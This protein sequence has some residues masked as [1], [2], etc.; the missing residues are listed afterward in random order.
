M[1]LVRLA[2]AA[3][4][5][6]C[7]AVGCASSRAAP[8][9]TSVQT[10]TVRRALAEDTDAARI[11]DHQSDVVPPSEAVAN[12][13]A[14]LDAI[15]LTHATPDFASAM[16]AHRDAWEALIAPLSR[17]PDERAEMHDLFGRLK[18]MPAPTGPEFQRLVQNVIATWSPVMDAAARAGVQP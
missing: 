14:A 13:V 10:S 15:D 7:I 3:C 18:S 2:F 16:R 11:R 8:G 4:A 6:A 5:A 17:F 12:Y 9:V 1:A